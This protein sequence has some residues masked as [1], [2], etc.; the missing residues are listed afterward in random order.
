VHQFLTEIQ[1]EQKN[2]LLLPVVA[3]LSEW[4]D[5]SKITLAVG[6]SRAIT[7]NSTKPILNT[8]LKS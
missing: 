1:L 3:R 5:A 4:G 6:G 8:T 7:V 2:K